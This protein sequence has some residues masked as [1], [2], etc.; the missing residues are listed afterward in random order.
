MCCAVS[1]DSSRC[2]R[3]RLFRFGGLL[4]GVVQLRRRPSTRPSRSTRLDWTT[5]CSTACC[6]PSSALAFRVTCSDNA[7]SE[8]SRRHGL[9][10]LVELRQRPAFVSL[11]RSKA[12]RCLAPLA[13]LRRY[14][15][16]VGQARGRRRAESNELA[17]RRPGLRRGLFNLVFRIRGACSAALRGPLVLLQANRGL[18]VKHLRRQLLHGFAMPATSPSASAWSRPGAHSP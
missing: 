8:A 7:L 15:R 6:W 17:F 4:H 9:A 5:A 14:L 18:R 2:V 10:Q 13:T 12:R 11:S 1:A 3:N 16:V